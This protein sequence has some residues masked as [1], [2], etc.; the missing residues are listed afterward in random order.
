[1]G[2]MTHWT[3]MCPP[4]VWI[5]L[6]GFEL[7]SHFWADTCKSCDPPASFFPA[8]ANDVL[9]WQSCN[10]GAAESLRIQ[11]KAALENHM[12]PS[13]LDLSKKQTCC[14]PG[15]EISGVSLLP[16]HSLA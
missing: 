16:Q 4:G 7:K 14:C 12:M 6:V 8:T 3:V 15:S 1:M 2:P 5:W 13:G 10:M 11:R 9:T